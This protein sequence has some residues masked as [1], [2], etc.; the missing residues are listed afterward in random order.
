[1]VLPC[2]SLPLD[3]YLLYLL[4]PPLPFLEIIF[5]LIF[6]N[7]ILSVLEGK[8]QIPLL[9]NSARTESVSQLKYQMCVPRTLVL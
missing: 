7:Q 1:M 9:P 2:L 3:S 4:I 5:P 6:I 8:A